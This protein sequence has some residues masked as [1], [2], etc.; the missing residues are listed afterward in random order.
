M[1]MSSIMRCRSGETLGVNELM[2]ALQSKSEADRLARQLGRTSSATSN[3]ELAGAITA[4][5]V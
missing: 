4:I 5:A 2:V 3:H 1:R